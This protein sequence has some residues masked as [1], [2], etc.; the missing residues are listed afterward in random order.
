MQ[1]CCSVKLALI[2]LLM[3]PSAPDDRS[4]IG[5]MMGNRLHPGSL[6]F[7]ED[8]G[9][10]GEFYYLNGRREAE[11]TALLHK[12]D[13]RWQVLLS[14]G[15]AMDPPSAYQYGLPRRLCPKLGW[16]GQWDF[17]DGP[18]WESLSQGTVSESQLRLVGRNWVLTLMRN[19][20]Y[21]RHGHV[22]ADPELRNYF[23][24]RAWYR[25][26]RETP[27]SSPELANVRA[28][29]AYQQSHKLP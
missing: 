22:F 29:A 17:K 26:G 11:G 14:A 28:I 19:E 13:G 27:L 24:Q 8:W 16:K 12:M 6:R 20:V 25:P 21:A 18:Y 2:L 10:C 1:K 5:E 3:L 15:G 9:V 7:A 4:E 23:K